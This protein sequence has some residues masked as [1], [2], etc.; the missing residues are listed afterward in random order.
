MGNRQRIKGQTI[1]W[2]YC[3][4]FYCSLYC[5]SFVYS[6][7]Y[8]LSF[9]L[10]STAHCIVCPFQTIQWAIEGQTMQ[11]AIE[12]QTMQ[13]TID[14]GQTIQWSIE[15]QTI[16]WTDNTT[17]NCLSF[18]WP[19]YCLSFVYCPLN[20]LSFYPLSIA[21]CILC[22]FILC[23]LPI[24]LSVLLLPIVLSVLSLLPITDNTMG[25]DKGQT[26]QWTIDKGQ[27]TQRAIEK[28]QTIQ[29]AIDRT[30]NTMGNRRTDNLG[31]LPI[32]LSVLLSFVY[33]PLYCLSFYPLSI[34]H[35]I[36][37]PLSIAHYIVWPF[38]PFLLSIVLQRIKGQTMQW[39]IDKG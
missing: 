5:L 13:W 15:G 28:G 29:W 31:L 36:V 33:C 16:Q 12:G 32:V 18:Y 25:I 30:N 11:W 14:K 7:L 21:H 2:L 35:C 38:I 34:A 37:R 22:P 4:S 19:L 6:P 3:L 27:T 26:I 20:C 39:A 1:Q 10:L 8:C 9:Y 24:A 17:L 23:L